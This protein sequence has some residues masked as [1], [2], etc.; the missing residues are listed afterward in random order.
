MTFY[1][2]KFLDLPVDYKVFHSEQLEYSSIDAVL[3]GL[4]RYDSK[5][6]IQLGILLLIFTP[7]AR[8]VFSV[9][10]FIIE[11]D[12]LYVAIG[13]SV[14]CIILLSLSYNIVH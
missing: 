2:F 10:S 8:V 12:Y 14:L 9:F 4:S 7:I 5:A 13:L 1:L 11:R 6:I 3:I